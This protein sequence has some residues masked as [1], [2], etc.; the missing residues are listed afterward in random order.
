MLDFFRDTLSA[1]AILDYLKHLPRTSAYHQALA[2]DEELAARL[3]NEPQSKPGPPP[4]TEFGPDVQVLAELRDLAAA[5]LAVT[6][7]AHGGKPS[8]V[9]PYPRPE[10]ALQRARRRARFQ[11][12]RSV[13]ARVLPPGS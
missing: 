2:Q 12:H 7:K 13:V 8:K 4:L 9:K 1:D 3:A 11:Q 6:V 5:L 10:T